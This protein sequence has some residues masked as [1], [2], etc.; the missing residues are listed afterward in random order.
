MSASQPITL[1]IIGVGIGG[2]NLAIAIPKHNPDL[3]LTL[4]E[5]RTEFSEIG[6]GV[7]TLFDT[8]RSLEPQNSH[9]AGF[10]PNAT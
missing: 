4:L 1:A 10:G 8:S 9:R 5:S 6:A 7:G 3:Q 2:I